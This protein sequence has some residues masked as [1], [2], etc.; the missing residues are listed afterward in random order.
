M[1]RLRDCINALDRLLALIALVL[2]PAILTGCTNPYTPPGEVGYLTR[3]PI[4]LPAHFVAL[5][6]GP[7]S[8]GWSYLIFVQNIRITPYTYDEQFTGAETVL[9][10][11]NLNIGFHLGIVWRVKKQRVKQFFEYYLPTTSASA[12]ANALAAY[13]AFLKT[14][15][16]SLAINEIQHLNALEIKDRIPEIQA[17]IL[18]GAGNYT[19]DTPFDIM[20]VAVNNV[21]YPPTVASSVSQMMAAT[22]HLERTKIEA[23]ARVAE[24]QGIAQ[25]MQIITNRLT[26]LYVQYEALKTQNLQINSPNHTVVYIPVGKLGIPL[27][28]S[29]DLS[30][31]SVH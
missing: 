24:A 15:I 20:A 6:T 1:M 31:K 13:E 22:Q 18:K 27:V 17:S 29:V 9:S 28:G 4:G 12:D 2:A 21:Q 7:R 3:H 5:Q 14:K 8:P 19:A 23:Q 30:Q 16:R 11:D 10:K 26:P 25:A